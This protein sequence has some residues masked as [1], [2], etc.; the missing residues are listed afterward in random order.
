MPNLL[1]QASALFVL[2]AYALAVLGGRAMGYPD[3]CL[4]HQ[5]WTGSTVLNVE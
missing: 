2:G 3:V 1:G 4:C 5:H